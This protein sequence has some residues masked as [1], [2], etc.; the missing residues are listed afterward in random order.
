[1]SKRQARIGGGLEGEV[2]SEVAIVVVGRR[3]KTEGE[4]ERKRERR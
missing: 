4:V 3:W 2:G 1:M